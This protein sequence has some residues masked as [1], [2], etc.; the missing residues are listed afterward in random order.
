MDN[1][2]RLNKED[3][4][5]NR[6][7]GKLK[8]YFLTIN[9]PN[10]GQ[11]KEH[12][13]KEAVKRPKVKHSD[14]H[15]AGWFLTLLS[16]VGV[17]R[18]KDGRADEG[19]SG[20]GEPVGGAHCKVKDLPQSGQKFDNTKK[21]KTKRMKRDQVET[22]TERDRGPK[23]NSLLTAGPSTSTGVQHVQSGGN[24]QSQTA[25]APDLHA[26]KL[27]SFNAIFISFL[28]ELTAEQLK[29]LRG[30]SMDPVMKTLLAE[31]LSESAQFVSE[32]VLEVIMPAVVKTHGPVP[33]VSTKTRRSDVKVCKIGQNNSSTPSLSSSSNGSQTGVPRTLG[34]GGF[35]S[36]EPLRD[37]F[38]ITEE[39]LLS[40]IKDPFRVLISKFL[41]VQRE[42]QLDTQTL[43]RVIV[44][45]VSKKVNSMISD[46]IQTPRFTGLQ[47]PVIFSSGGVSNTKVIEEM[48]SGASVA[49]QMF[50]NGQNIGEQNIVFD[51]VE[52][53]ISN[54][55]GQ[56]MTALSETAL[57]CGDKEREKAY[58]EKA[59]L[60]DV[61]WDNIKELVTGNSWEGKLRYGQAHHSGHGAK[62][63]ISLSTQSMDRLLTQEFQTKATD[64]IR[65]VTRRFFYYSS[66]CS[67]VPSTMSIHYM[68]EMGNLWER[69][70]AIMDPDATELLNTFVSKMTS[71]TQ[72]IRSSSSPAER[73]Q[74]LLE[75]HQCKIWSCTV[76]CYNSM[77]STLKRIFVC[78]KEEILGTFVEP[79][80]GSST[81]VATL[82]P[83]LASQ[84]LTQN[85]VLFDTAKEIVNQVL[86]L[87]NG[88]SNSEMSLA[89][90]GFVDAILADLNGSTDLDASA[91]VASE[92]V[93]TMAKDVDSFTQMIQV[94]GSAVSAKDQIGT[95]STTLGDLAAPP[96]QVS[97]QK[98]AYLQQFCHLH[99]FLKCL[100]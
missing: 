58:S 67:V 73:E 32:A 12:F 34:D 11:Q 81:L 61:V 57:S 91:T 93:K 44:E 51:D 70:S 45:D 92:I 76:D 48:V 75:N 89:A 38:G 52:A 69:N 24:V 100:S 41:R 95:F 65:N 17:V 53:D 88:G 23:S 97:G 40:D 4:K 22:I 46:A 59:D 68:S 49:L 42:V 50:V 80:A 96:S 28:E 36:S 16:L 2:K 13:P 15:A 30:C 87:S 56:L 1:R 78:P 55:T 99:Y 35:K 14:L 94:S 60:L 3:R 33:P 27:D 29:L 39:I 64:T 9:K 83:G 72:S 77:K 19:G 6:Q 79:T 63:N 90:N 31:M 20:V 82:R 66:C 71:L 86:A 84:M 26:V 37:L 8:T 43:F 25:R 10:G 74:I 54:L 7:S 5:D 47:G 62:W 21:V 98:A 85:H 18:P